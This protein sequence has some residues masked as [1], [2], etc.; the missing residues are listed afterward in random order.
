MK[1]SS[2]NTLTT[3]CIN[4]GVTQPLLH[5]PQPSTKSPSFTQ[6]W[7]DVLEEVRSSR[8]LWSVTVVT[9]V[10]GLSAM[11][12]GY[13]MGYPSFTLVELD[14]LDAFPKDSVLAGL[15]GVSR[16]VSCMCS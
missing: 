6:S 11:V 16:H 1:T 4:N 12:S 2:K 13:T 7:K 15:F 3:G 9:V 8:R 14:H 10:S 5:A